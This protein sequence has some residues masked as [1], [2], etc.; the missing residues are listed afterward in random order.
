MRNAENSPKPRVINGDI[1]KCILTE[2]FIGKDLKNLGFLH[3]IR[4]ADMYR[5]ERLW[6]SK[7]SPS[8]LIGK[9]SPKT[10]TILSNMK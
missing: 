9:K 8:V 2:V 1:A 7:A 10:H 6:D 4:E 3:T 5:I